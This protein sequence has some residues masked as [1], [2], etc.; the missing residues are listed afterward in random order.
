MHSFIIY[1]HTKRLDNLLQTLRFLEINHL[2]TIKQSELVLICQDSCNSIDNGFGEYQHHNMNLPLMHL[3]LFVN[4]GVKYAKYNKL[5]I[6]ESDRILPKGYFE[7]ILQELKLGVMVTTKKMNKLTAT[8]TNEEIINGTYETYCDDRSEI[9]QLGVKNMWSGNTAC[10]KEDFELVGKMD[11]FYKGYGWAD[12]DMTLTME[13]A[14]IQSIYKEDYTELHLWHEGKTYGQGD[15]KQMYHNNCFYLCKKWNVPIP[16]FIEREINMNK[17]VIYYWWDNY[18]DCPHNNLRV[19]IILSIATLRAHNPSIPIYVMDCSEKQ[20]NWRNF[21]NSLNFQVTPWTMNLP[22][23]NFM[24]RMIDIQAFVKQIPEDEIIYCDSD[25]FWLRNPL[26]FFESPDFFCSNRHNNGFFYFDKTSPACCQ[27]FELFKSYSMLI[28]NDE[29]FKKEILSQDVNKFTTSLD[30]VISNR[31]FEIKP[32]IVKQIQM[33]E[34]GFIRDIAHDKIDVKDIKM[35][36]CNGLLVENKFNKINANQ[37][38][39]RGLV[40]LIFKE[41]Y[42][43]ITNVLSESE[44]ESIFTRDELNYYIP[45]QF[46]ILNDKFAEQLKLLNVPYNKDIQLKDLM[47]NMNI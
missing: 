23:H 35:I 36:H 11:E 12:C 4:V 2:D 39:A 27:F 1:F 7:E 33:S 8:A 20:L 38:H 26:P 37:K 28:L 44:I 13:K 40:C 16:H 6:L 14:G 46:E 41:L 9:C 18:E 21:E 25:V 3:P 15:Q 5:V 34:H 17:A 32:K 31:I 42:Q 45:L 24:S 19:P 29:K 22:E 10:M 43:A 30:E 47:V